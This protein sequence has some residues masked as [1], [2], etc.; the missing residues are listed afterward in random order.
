[1]RATCL[2]HIIF[3]DLLA[4]ITLTEKRIFILEHYEGYEFLICSSDFHGGYW[5][6]GRPFGFDTIIPEER[7]VPIFRVMEFVKGQEDSRG[8]SMSPAPS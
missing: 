1:V 5:P 2:A 4:R 8:D 6:D 7:A 3:F